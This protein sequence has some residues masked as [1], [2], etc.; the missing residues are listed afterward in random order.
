[1]SG[2]CPS[3]SGYYQTENGCYY[4]SGNG[5]GWA[6]H[7]QACRDLGMHLVIINSEQEKDEVYDVW[8]H[9][10]PSYSM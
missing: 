1:M 7:D 6:Q 10:M 2:P 5:G 3:G 9:D 4:W 8:H